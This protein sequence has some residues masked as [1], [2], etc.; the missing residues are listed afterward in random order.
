MHTSAQWGNPDD[1][2][3]AFRCTKKE[4]AESFVNKGAI[5][6]NSPE[7]WVNEA[8][9]KGEGRGDRLEGTIAACNHSEIENF[10][11][12]YQKYKKYNDLF[13]TVIDD[14]AYFKRKKVMNLPC[15]CF[16]ILKNS[17]FTCPNEEGKHRLKT[18]V[19]SSYFKD[20]AN[21]LE[22]EQEE[23]LPESE[24]PS[25]VIIK[26]FELFRTRLKK[27][28]FKLGIMEEEIIEISVAYY[29]YFQYG[30]N[31]WFDLNKEPPFELSVKSMKFIYQNELRFII[32]TK[33]IDIKEYLRNNVIEIGSLSDISKIANNYF[34]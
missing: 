3:M 29:D 5:K 14:V 26:D 13:C 8:S 24:K 15:Y 23:K 4:F 9:V 31:G 17:M 2:M 32:N 1:F 11:Q 10:S 27:H 33:N 18:T 19:P 16:Y 20:F 25:L 34:L 12:L 6:F 22:P 28:L 7:S 21:N 30:R